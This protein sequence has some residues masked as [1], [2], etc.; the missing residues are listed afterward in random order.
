MALNVPISKIPRTQSS[1]SFVFDI[2]TDRALE[3]AQRR[4]NS[5]ARTPY[6]AANSVD[7]QT[8]SYIVISG[9]TGCNEICSAFGEDVCYVLPVSDNGGSSSEIIR[10][11]G[12]SSQHHVFSQPVS[13]NPIR[14]GGPSIGTTISPPVK[15]ASIY[16]RL[17]FF[18]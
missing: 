11:I 12:R 1:S 17:P 2:P 6:T 7:G 10:V 15:S 4:P 3:L 9:G 5:E 18:A 14:I 16:Q 13:L 8:Q